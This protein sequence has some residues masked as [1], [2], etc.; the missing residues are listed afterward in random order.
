MRS[1]FVSLPG[2]CKYDHSSYDK[3]EAI[4]VVRRGTELMD[5]RRRL[6]HL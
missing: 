2:R 6:L 1:A 4:D 3:L 5:R